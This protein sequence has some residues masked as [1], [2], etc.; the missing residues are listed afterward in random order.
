MKNAERTEAHII[1]KE[2]KTEIFI[3]NLQ[4]TLEEENEDIG[5]LRGN[6]GAV[7]WR[8]PLTQKTEDYFEHGT[9]EHIGTAKLDNRTV[10]EMR[11]LIK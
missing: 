6:P 11:E 3:N 7:F 2:D 1:E 8:A 4:I 9:T 10:K 5:P